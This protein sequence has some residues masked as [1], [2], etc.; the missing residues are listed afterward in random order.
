MAIYVLG[1]FYIAGLNLI[2]HTEKTS[3]AQLPPLAEKRTI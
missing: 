1:Y 3:R 2:Q